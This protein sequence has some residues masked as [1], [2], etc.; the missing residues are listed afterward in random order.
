MAREMVGDD[1][2]EIIDFWLDMMRDPENPLRLRLEASKLL[3]ERGWGRAGP[4]DVPLPA[5]DTL[6]APLLDER[7][8]DASIKEFYAE[9]DRLAATG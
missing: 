7:R 3:A 2:R 1:G 8:L 5:T 9:L 6:R 4:A